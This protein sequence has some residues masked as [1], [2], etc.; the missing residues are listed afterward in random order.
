MMRPILG[1]IGAPFAA[2][3]SR[4]R[5]SVVACS[6]FVLPLLSSY[7]L[8]FR[9]YRIHQTLPRFLSAPMQMILRS[10]SLPRLAANDTP[11]VSAR[12]GVARAHLLLDVRRDFGGLANA[13]EA[14]AER[15]ACGPCRLLHQE[16]LERLGHAGIGW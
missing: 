16:V 3:P 14:A 7:R 11:E 4:S 2:S 15:G 13:P 10:P 6:R 1:L 12:A 5:S 8:P 9:L